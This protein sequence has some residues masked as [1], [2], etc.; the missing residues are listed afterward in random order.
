MGDG[1]FLECLEHTVAMAKGC[2]FELSAFISATLVHGSTESAWAEIAFN[3][4]DV[5][6]L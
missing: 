4:T 1:S 3:P 5:E 2:L 6:Y